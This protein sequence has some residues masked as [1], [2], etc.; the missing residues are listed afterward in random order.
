MERKIEC[1]ATEGR[2][3][4]VQ[5]LRHAWGVPPLLV[6]EALAV[7]AKWTVSPEAPLLGELSN[8]VRLRGCTKTEPL[9]CRKVRLAAVFPV[10]FWRNNS[11]V[12]VDNYPLFLY[13]IIKRG[14]CLCYIACV[15]DK[16]WNQKRFFPFS[17]WAF[18]SCLFCVCYTT[19]L[20]MYRHSIKTMP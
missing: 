5:P 16:H 9:L 10:S 14:K 12:Y 7:P 15:F 6:G 13:S 20:T 8:G 17:I 1:P 3:V 19:K 18:L 11:Y 4:F 2:L